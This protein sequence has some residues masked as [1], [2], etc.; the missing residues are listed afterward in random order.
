MKLCGDGD[1]GACFQSFSWCFQSHEAAGLSI[2][3]SLPVFLEFLE[4]IRITFKG[5]FFFFLEI[6]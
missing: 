2:F 1:L 3:H 5:A 4:Q 6:L